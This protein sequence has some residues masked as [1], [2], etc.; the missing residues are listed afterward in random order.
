MLLNTKVFAAR[1]WLANRCS[2]VPNRGEQMVRYYA[3]LAIMR[4]LDGRAIEFA[5]LSRRCSI[6]GFF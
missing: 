1:E 6:V 4:S 5:I 3:E 2:H